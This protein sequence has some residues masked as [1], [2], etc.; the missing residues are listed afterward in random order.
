MIE[1]YYFWKEHC[2]PCKAARPLIE[3]VAADLK[4]TLH[5]LD[6][7]STEG[8]AYITPWNLLAVPTL[9]IAQD[10]R[11]ITAVTGAELQSADKLHKQLT[12]L[13]SL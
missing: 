5:A 13:L 2:A 6:V 9:V 10:G 1:L 4:L 7:R 8:E 12:K 11:K 3:R